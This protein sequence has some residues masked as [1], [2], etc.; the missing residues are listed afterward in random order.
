MVHVD[1][2]EQK[3]SRGGKAK[4]AKSVARKPDNPQRYK[5]GAITKPN[6]KAAA[7]KRIFSQTCKRG[8]KCPRTKALSIG[9]TINFAEMEV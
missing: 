5:G 7:R 2:H 1:F 6:K 4:L 8:G 9:S 3:P